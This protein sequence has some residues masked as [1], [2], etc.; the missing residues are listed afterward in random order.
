MISAV[1]LLVFH[2]DSHLPVLESLKR[3]FIVLCPYF[4]KPSGLKCYEML[5][6]T[7]DY[8]L[9][10]QYVCQAIWRFFS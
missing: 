7:G 8:L 6:A 2:T 10:W 1:L 9:A 5:R 4:Y 3:A